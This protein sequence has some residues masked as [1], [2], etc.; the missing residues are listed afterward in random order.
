[1]PFIVALIALLTPRL[2]IV[3][4]WLLT[5]WFDGLF[6][7]SLW[8]ILGF[9]FL[10]TTFLWYTAVLHW[11]GGVWSLWPVVGIIVALMIDL[12]LSEVARGKLMVAAKEGRAIPLGW[13]LDRDGNPTT[14]PQAGLEGSM[15][16]AGGA[17]GAMLVNGLNELA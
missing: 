11:W 1:M 2:V 9:L 3:L 15:L 4:L 7:T 17:K 16:P 6:R 12:S 14:D 5:R 10:P 8:P 13:A